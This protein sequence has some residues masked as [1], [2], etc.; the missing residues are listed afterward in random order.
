MAELSLLWRREGQTGDYWSVCVMIEGTESQRP[1][2]LS[3]SHTRHRSAALDTLC[4]GSYNG[5]EEESCEKQITHTHIQY[6]Y[7]IYKTVCQVNTHE[8]TLATTPTE[9]RPDSPS[10]SHRGHCH[11]VPANQNPRD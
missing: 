7:K 5:E 6:I 1:L 8:H 10:A 11:G 2:L 3:G 4:G 9:G